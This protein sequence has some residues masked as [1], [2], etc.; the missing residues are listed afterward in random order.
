M[1]WRLTFFLAFTSL[2]A[3]F[4]QSIERESFLKVRITSS[5][6][7][8]EITFSAAWLFKSA[9]NEISCGDLKTPYEIIGP[10]EVFSGIFK[11]KKG[12]A[13][14][15]VEL[16]QKTGETERLVEESQGNVI[17]IDKKFGQ[18]SSIGF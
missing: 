5:D 2:S 14:L 7:G 11:R 6:P 3:V 15:V 10:A 13:E 18:H 4:A 17:L 8:V 12:D 9:E 16:I 1:Y